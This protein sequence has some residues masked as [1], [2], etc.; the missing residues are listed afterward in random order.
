M[1]TPLHQLYVY[2]QLH[3]PNALG[4][5]YYQTQHLWFIRQHWLGLLLQNIA[6]H[7]ESSIFSVA[8]NKEWEVGLEILQ[9]HGQPLLCLNIR[10]HTY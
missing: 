5:M 2:W 3:L 4:V 1:N 8:Q 10:P 7:T 9:T 6:F